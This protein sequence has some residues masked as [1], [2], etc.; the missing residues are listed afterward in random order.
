MHRPREGR[1]RGPATISFIVPPL[2]ASVLSMDCMSP[3]PLSAA[4]L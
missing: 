3:L 1:D 4:W 2:L